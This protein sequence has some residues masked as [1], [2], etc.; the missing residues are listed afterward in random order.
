MNLCCFKTH[1]IHV[2]SPDP[3][4]E[5]CQ[6]NSGA[7]AQEELPIDGHRFDPSVSYRPSSAMGILKAS[8]KISV[9]TVP[10]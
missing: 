4:R 3:R 5:H 8:R 10:E 6:G 9:N 1:A 2:A 7:K